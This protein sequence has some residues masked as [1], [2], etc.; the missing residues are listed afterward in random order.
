MGLD[1]VALS[2]DARGDNDFL[3]SELPGEMMF[4][5]AEASCKWRTFLTEAFGLAAIAFS[6]ER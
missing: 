3:V 4:F 2:E 6:D 1:N 5:A